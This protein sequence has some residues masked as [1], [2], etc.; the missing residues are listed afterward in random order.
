[1]WLLVMVLLTEVSGLSGVTVLNKF[2]TYE[3]CL[4]ERD[5]IGY[6]MAEAYPYERDFVIECRAKKASLVLWYRKSI[7]GIAT[8]SS[9]VS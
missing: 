6:A 8:V 4:V 7:A 9:W 3:E 5:R 1:M 2:E